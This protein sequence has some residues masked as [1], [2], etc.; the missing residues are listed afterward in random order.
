M[1]FGDRQNLID[2]AISIGVMNDDLT[3]NLLTSN[4]QHDIIIDTSEAEADENDNADSDTIIIDED[5]DNTVIKKVIN[6]SL[7]QRKKTCVRLDRVGLVNQW[8]L[9]DGS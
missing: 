6:Q 1:K 5:M 9:V 2:A 7:L 8:I 4:L 3:D